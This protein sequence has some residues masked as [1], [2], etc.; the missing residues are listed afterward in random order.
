MLSLSKQVSK[1]FNS[2]FI[3]TENASNLIPLQPIDVRT[4]CGFLVPYI[5]QKP[6]CGNLASQAGL[7]RQFVNLA[8]HR[9]ELR[10]L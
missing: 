1:Y 10:T 9:V 4:H 2:L 8:C 7:F 6:F 5:L 3:F